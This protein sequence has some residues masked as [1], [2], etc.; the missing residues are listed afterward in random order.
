MSVTARGVLA[1]PCSTLADMLSN[2]AHFQKLVKA[3][4]A[5]AALG[6][7][8]E[9]GQQPAPTR[10]FAL[11]SSELYDPQ[12]LAGGSRDW[13]QPLGSLKAQFEIPL[14]WSGVNTSTSATVFDVTEFVGLDD[15]FFNGLE[16][17]VTSGAHK[18]E[19]GTVGDFAG[20][21]GRVTLSAPL[22]G[23]LAPGD[24]VEIR[25]ATDKDGWTWFF[26]V[27]GDIVSDLQALSGTGGC[28]SLRR[29]KLQEY[30]RALKETEA[31][32]WIGA[33]LEMEYGL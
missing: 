30:G 15:D 1:L 11:V 28:L 16:F 5:A 2:C 27:L 17:Y 7:I 24:A 33:I 14:A 12:L 26:N 10:P 31:T 4:N 29:M 21:Q 20:T 22:T 9:W 19:H 8:Y 6:S 13:Y 32:D 3:A 18:E 25:P 23:N